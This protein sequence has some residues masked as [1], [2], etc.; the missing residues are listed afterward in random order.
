[1]SGDFSDG[2]LKCRRALCV[3]G[4]FSLVIEMQEGCLFQEIVLL[5]N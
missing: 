1:V 5:C 4:I 2:L 3:S